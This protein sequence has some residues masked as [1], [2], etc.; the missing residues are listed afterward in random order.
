MLRVDLNLVVTDDREILLAFMV[1]DLPISVNLLDK[2]NFSVLS[3]RLFMV[4]DKMLQVIIL[5]DAPWVEVQPI[6]VNVGR[7]VL[8]AIIPKVFVIVEFG[9]AMDLALS[10]LLIVNIH[11][12]VV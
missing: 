2:V 8:F 11:V 10:S 7:D 6:S 9:E 1:I 5:S 4:F 3:V 12:L